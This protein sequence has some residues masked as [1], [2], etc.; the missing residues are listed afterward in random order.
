PPSDDD[1]YRSITLGT[2]VGAAMPAFYWLDETDRWALVLRVKEFSP[3]LRGSGLRSPR[4]AGGRGGIDPAGGDVPQGGEAEAALREGRRLWDG[5]GCASC[6]GPSG[7]GLT[8][9]EAGADWKDGDGVAVPRSG[10]LTH[11]CALRA[12]ASERALERAVLFGVGEAMPSYAES[13]PDAPGLRALVSFLRS[14]Q[15][16]PGGAAGRAMGSGER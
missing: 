9:Q 16:S 5:L 2:G 8:R 15:R 3:V 7:S 14:L 13:L 4:E 10:D 6:H 11:A 1:L 12:G